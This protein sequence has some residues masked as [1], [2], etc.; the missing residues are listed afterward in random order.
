MP[1]LLRSPIL[2]IGLALIAVGGG[3]WINGSIKLAEY[4]A[5]ISQGDQHVG[6][7]SYEGYRQLT[8]EMNAQL[9]RP[10]TNNMASRS[11]PE[12]KRE[13]YIVVLRG[14]R[15]LTLFGAFLVLLA[16]VRHRRRR[17]GRGAGQAVQGE[18]QRA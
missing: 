9:L 16:V 11:R 17:P 15:L 1:R 10:L 18:A 2:G 14:G 3:N 12:E 7:G 8:A 5:V 13:F 4:D 6:A